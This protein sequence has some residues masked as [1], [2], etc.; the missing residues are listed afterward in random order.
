[1]GM[2]EHQVRRLLADLLDIG[3]V[4]AVQAS[5]LR[6]KVRLDEERVTDWIRQGVE[7]AGGTRDWNPLDV[8]EQVLIACPLGG[9]PVIICSLNRDQ[10]PQPA[11]NLEQFYRAFKDGSWIRYD[12]QNHEL[13]F[14]CV[15]KVSGTAVA[16]FHLVGDLYL[17]G[18]IVS[19]GDQVAGGVSTMHH[20]TSGVVPGLGESG[21]P[22]Q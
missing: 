2:S 15:G 5:P 18:K 21:E 10:Y 11:E 1:M 19:T 22:V 12:R 14:H 13:S 16:G 17:E 8:G 20:K 6:Y 4:D 9:L 7:R 3:T